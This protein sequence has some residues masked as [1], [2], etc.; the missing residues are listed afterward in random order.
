MESALHSVVRSIPIGKLVINL[1]ENKN[2]A[3]DYCKLPDLA[4]KWALIIDSQI[5]TGDFLS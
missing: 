5:T 2:P 1:D 4:G 3:L